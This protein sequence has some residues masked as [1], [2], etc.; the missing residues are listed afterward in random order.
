[1]MDTHAR[2]HE[3]TLT[4]ACALGLAL[5]AIG[6]G[7]RLV[8][9][10]LPGTDLLWHMMP[11][12]ALALFV[13]SRLRMRWAV[14]LPLGTMLISDLLLIR[15]LASQGLAAFGWGS[16][17]VYLSFAL[18]VLIG[19]LIG[20]NEL[21][22]MVVGGAALLGSLQFFLI[23]NLPPWL[24]DPAYSKNLSG[25]LTCYIYGVPFY[26]GTLAGDLFFSGLIFGLHAALVMPASRQ[27]VSQP[28]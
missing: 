28:V 26:R 13:G 3:H 8:P 2:T 1:M 11:V 18:Y 14:L 7:C 24:I 25:L 10:Y 19:R 4:L 23:T 27:K 22:P 6:V 5:A 16:L 20:P 12:G 15:P 9:R 21:S 17:V